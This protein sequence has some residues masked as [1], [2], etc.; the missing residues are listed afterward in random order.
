MKFTHFFIDR[1]IFAGV[2]SLLLLIA[3]TIAAFT[4]PIAEYPEVSPP[5]IVVASAQY[6]GANPQVVADTVSAPLEQEITGVEDMIYMNSQ[7]QQDGTLQLT[8]VF[9]LGADIDRAQ[10]QVQNRVA[11]ALPRL[12]PEVTALGVTARKS[13]PDLTMV[14]HFFSPDDRYDG[15]YL[16]NYALIQVRDALARI[17]GAGDVR[18]FRFGRLCDARV[19]RSAKIG[20]AQSHRRRCDR[21]DSRTKYSSRGRFGRRGADEQRGRFSTRGQCAGTFAQRATIRRRDYQNRRR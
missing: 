14:V 20:G 10:V 17:P 19:A 5:T 6:P 7:A 18:L 13:S 21:S 15:L 2:L 1:P 4:L 12:P 16:R 3:G 8:I 9:K 11:Q